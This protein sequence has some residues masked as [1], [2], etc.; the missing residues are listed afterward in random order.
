MLHYVLSTG[1]LVGV[2]LLVISFIPV[3]KIALVE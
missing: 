2:E 1:R 3:V